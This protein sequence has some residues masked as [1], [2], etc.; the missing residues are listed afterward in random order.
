[1]EMTQKLEGGTL[2]VLILMEKWMTF[3]CTTELYRPK[4]ST[5]EV[6]FPKLEA[7][8]RVKGNN[9]D[10]QV[11]GGYNEYTLI[12][13]AAEYEID[14]YFVGVGSSV[15]AKIWGMIYFIFRLFISR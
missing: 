8:Y 6:K 10:F 11:A 13:G 7:K 14:S 9:W 5:A 12:S 4:K 3:E 1:M 2:V 15:V